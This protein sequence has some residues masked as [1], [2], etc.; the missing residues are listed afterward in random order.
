MLNYLPFTGHY[1]YFTT[2]VFLFALYAFC[3]FK[4]MLKLH[5]DSNFVIRMG[6]IESADHFC[7]FISLFQEHLKYAPLSFLFNKD[8]LIHSF[9][10][11]NLLFL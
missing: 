1:L 6:Y 4:I 7:H 2:S 11:N 10:Y 3:P 8:I 9:E 5:W